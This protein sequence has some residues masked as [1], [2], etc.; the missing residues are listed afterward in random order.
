[1]TELPPD[2]IGYPS[3][4][5]PPRSPGAPRSRGESAKEV[6]HIPGAGTAGMALLIVSLTM[7]FLASIAAYLVVR[8]E[9]LTRNPDAAT[10]DW[11]PAGLPGLPHS[12]WLSTLVILF[13]SYTIH[14]ALKAIQ[15]DDEKRLLRYLR[16]TFVLGLVFLCL[17][18]LN[19]LE[20]YRALPEG[21]GI[22]GVYLAGF[23]IL[24]ALHALHVIGGLIPLG[25]TMIHAKH[26]KYSRNF[27]PGVRYSAI[28]WH[29]LDAV[30]IALFVVMLI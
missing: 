10:P 23:Y 24:T 6:I 1:M 14:T 2:D 7:L 3:S 11:P 29:F 4:F 8:Y 20:F 28:Y 15:R 5:P 30:W 27:Y 17:Q 21:M 25:I 19:W 18:T 16:I 12:L 9:F 22:S 13:A 26:G